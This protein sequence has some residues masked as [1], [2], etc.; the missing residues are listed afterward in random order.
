MSRKT[1]FDELESLAE[2]LIWRCPT[3]F[4]SEVE[5][6]RPCATAIQ[7]PESDCLDTLRA[8]IQGSNQEVRAVGT[9]CQRVKNARIPFSSPVI[10]P[11]IAEAI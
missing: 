8:I 2:E 4:S 6:V 7:I 5:V 11:A 1:I 9:A 3:G 10:T